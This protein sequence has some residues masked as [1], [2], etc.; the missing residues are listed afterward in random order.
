MIKTFKLNLITHFYI[1]SAFYN[2]YR[3]RF[4]L[5]VDDLYFSLHIR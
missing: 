3:C 5:R 1:N 4:L 2:D